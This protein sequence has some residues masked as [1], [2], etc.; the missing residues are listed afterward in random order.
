MT[1][2]R[3]EGIEKRYSAPI[4]S[5]PSKSPV[6]M[7]KPIYLTV[8]EGE[9]FAL[10][11]PSG[12]GKTTLLKLVAGLLMPDRGDIRL[13]EESIKHIS[14]ENRGFGMVFQQP[15]LFPHMNVEENVAF[16]LKMQGVSR[17][18]RLAK[19]REMLT[20]VGLSDFGSRHPSALSGGQQQRV[21]LARALVTKPRLLLMDEPFSALDAGLR[22]EMRELVS[23]LHKELG[24]TILFVTHDRDEAFFLADRIGVMKDGDLLQVGRPQ[25]MYENP[26]SPDVALFLGA[27]NVVEGEA[28]GGWFSS[29]SFRIRIPNIHEDS[30][31][32]AGWL[33]LRPEIFEAV[34]EVVSSHEVQVSQDLPLSL[35]SIQGVVRQSA[36]R[37]GFHH[38]KVDV[39]T[40]ILDVMH[41]AMAD[42]RPMDGELITLTCDARNVHFIPK[43][44]KFLTK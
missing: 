2:L 28:V 6:F 27:R 32:R 3:L 7:L 15:L 13:D 22:E 4:F 17:S 16:G 21:S 9:F 5:G 39:G 24:T 35:S 43:S 10:L 29:N 18:G 44:P 25:K 20:A 19:A 26:N 40:Q 42:Y 23:S 41:K 12:C 8:D 31:H 14:A 1:Q 11:G 38:M 36:F 34:R 33:V 30:S 37:Q